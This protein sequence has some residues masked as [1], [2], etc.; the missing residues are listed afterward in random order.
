MLRGHALS[1]AVYFTER[2]CGICSMAHGFTAAQL[3]RQIYHTNL[4]REATLLQQLMLGAEFLQNHIRHFYLLALPDYM[5]GQ[6]FSSDSPQQ[7]PSR[8]SH[9]EQQQLLE[10]YNAAI[11]YSAKCHEML[12][13]FGGKIPHQHGLSAE[14]IAVTPTAD[15]RLQFISLLEPVRQF[16]RNVMLPDTFQLAETYPDYFEIGTRPA[17]FISFGLF[18]PR[19][20]GS[21]PSGAFDN[22]NR[23]PVKREEITESVSHSWFKESE[24]N[25]IKADLEKPGAYSW[26]K[27]PRYQGLAMEGGPLARKIIASSPGQTLSTGTMARLIARSEETHL[28]ASWMDEWIHEIPE[29][30]RYIEEFGSPLTL[31]ATQMNDA[32]R[33]PLLHSVTLKDDHIADYNVIT[34]TTWNFS[35]KDQQG[36]PGP[37]EESLIGTSLA[38]FNDPPEIGRIIRSFDPC[39]SCGTHLISIQKESCQ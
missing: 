16:I 22:F 38:H 1:D 8:F 18:D 10:H 25:P 4:S 32:P 21:F 33:G 3:V 19:Y 30:G 24:S 9:S 15:R 2:I 23:T 36:L 34:P 14:G 26:V 28:I 39:L 6:F 37:V 12:A 35:P 27:A 11:D 13:I 17:R 20:G 31:T 7:E 5:D 29:E